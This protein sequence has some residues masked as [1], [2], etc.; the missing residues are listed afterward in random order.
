MDEDN[1]SPA[2]V[3]E[4][5]ETPEADP[6]LA[7]LTDTEDEAQANVEETAV[8]EE[9]VEEAEPEAEQTDETTEE[10]EALIDPA[11]EA[12]RRYEER[13]AAKAESQRRVQEVA[14]EHIKGAE[15]EYDQRLR[16]MEAEAYAQ[17][18]EHNQNTLIGEFERAKANPDL[19]IFNPESDQFNQK[20]YDKALRDFNAGYV[21]YDTSGNMVGLKGSLFEHLTET[22]EL[23]QGAVKS[24]AVQQVRAAKTMQSNADSKPAATPKE[25]AKDNILEILM[26]D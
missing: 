8:A 19:Q 2:E 20:A 15:D 17:K 23:F 4:T 21:D 6:I 3:V 24:G 11:E 22:A 18:V 9:A 7:T 5:V 25:P 12:R 14:D 1:T 13:Q 26:S 10:V 16:T